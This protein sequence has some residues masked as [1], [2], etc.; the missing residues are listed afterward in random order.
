MSNLDEIQKE[1]SKIVHEIGVFFINAILMNDDVLDTMQKLR[2]LKKEEAKIK[3]S[4][5]D[6]WA[7]KE[8]NG[9]NVK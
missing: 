3:S 5:E 2:N 1:Y 6:P 8:F 4:K 9:E 7:I